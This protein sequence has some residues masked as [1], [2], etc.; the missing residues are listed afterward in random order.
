[1]RTPTA[2]LAGALV[3][4][5]ATSAGAALA[6][7]PAP[8][9]AVA[10]VDLRHAYS[11]HTR[12]KK[13]NESLRA[14]EEQIK[15]RLQAEEG[16]LRKE[17]QDLEVRFAPG[18]ED[19]EKGRKDI[20]MKFAPVAYDL[21]RDQM[22]LARSQVQGMTAAYKEVITEAERIASE[23]GYTCVLNFDHEEIAIEDGGKL[24]HPDAVSKQMIDRTTLWAS[25]TVDLTKD[26]I[27]A[28][29]KK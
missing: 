8:A 3:A 18:S 15:A 25:G 24:L 14:Q 29:S 2:V 20:E 22:R 16:K 7:R 17:I 26:V 13:L 27:E 9:C 1:M 11:E 6:S 28:L 23:R 4:V 21:K 10:V 12:A 19:Y 5:V